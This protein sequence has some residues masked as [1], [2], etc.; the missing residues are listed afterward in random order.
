[1][2]LLLQLGFPKCHFI[3]KETSFNALQHFKDRQVLSPIPV[4]NCMEG[5]YHSLSVSQISGFNV[6]PY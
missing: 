3:V 4:F 2:I 6:F 1:M 5:E